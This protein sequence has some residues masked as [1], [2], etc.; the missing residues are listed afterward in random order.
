MSRDAGLHGARAPP[1]F[2]LHGSMGV[3]RASLRRPPPAA[4]PAPLRPFGTSAISASHSILF[5]VRRSCPPLCLQSPGPTAANGPIFKSGL[6][7]GSGEFWWAVAN[8]GW[9]GVLAG[10]GG[11][12][13][14]KPRALGFSD[15]RWNTR[16]SSLAVAKII[17]PCAMMSCRPGRCHRLLFQRRLERVL[18]GR[19][20]RMKS[21]AALHN[22]AL[23][24]HDF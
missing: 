21:G 15:A 12:P 20:A 3:P 22:P 1:C 11:S 9:M 6:D 7:L 16:L 13:V 2:R 24:S 14:F 17:P 19:R 8:A 4:R 10:L 23:L 18:V 5:L